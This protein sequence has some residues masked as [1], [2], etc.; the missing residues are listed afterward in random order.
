MEISIR[1]TR[2]FASS[3]HAAMRRRGSKNY[4]NDVLID[5]VA[6]FLPNGELGWKTVAVA[7]QEQSREEVLRDHADIKKHWIK[8]LCNEMKKPTGA[9]G[10]NNDRFAR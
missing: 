1:L 9:T 5:I 4:K 2:L 7:Y 8:K 10:E 6:K 3:S